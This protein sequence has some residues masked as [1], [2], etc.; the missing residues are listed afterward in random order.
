MVDASRVN[1]LTLH[2]TKGL[3]FSRVYVVGVEDAS[4][5]GGTASRRATR[6]RHRGGAA[7]ALRRDDAG[8][9]PARVHPRGAA[10][11]RA[12]GRTSVPRRDG[13]RALT[14]LTRRRRGARGRA[15]SR[16]AGDRRAAAARRRTTAH[17]TPRRSRRDRRAT[18]PSDWAARRAPSSSAR[19][20]RGAARSSRAGAAERP[21]RTARGGTPSLPRPTPAR[22][23]CATDS[24]CAA[25]IRR[26][27]SAVMRGTARS[28][29][30]PSRRIRIS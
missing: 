6:R 2:S 12:D 9:G 15:P 18:P 5:I 16:A 22:S 29:M 23:R 10:E 11:G 14:R 7:A 24:A 20:C 8:E 3:E 1:L 27:S 19:P 25:S 17:D 30:S 13:D 4:L 28:R 21:V 26:Q